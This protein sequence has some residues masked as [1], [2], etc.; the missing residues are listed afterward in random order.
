MSKRDGTDKLAVI[1]VSLILLLPIMAIVYLIKGIIYLI[2]F[3][4]EKKLKKKKNKF[5]TIC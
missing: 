2:T 4:S 1:L 5:I 3:I